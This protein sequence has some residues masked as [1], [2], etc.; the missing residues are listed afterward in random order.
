MF[1]LGFV[2]LRGLLKSKTFT[3]PREESSFSET[4]LMHRVDGSAATSGSWGR[5]THP[6]VVARVT[7][8]YPVA[9]ST[10]GFASLVGNG[11]EPH[12]LCSRSLLT[13]TVR[14]LET[15][16][17]GVTI[18]YELE[19]FCPEEAEAG[20]DVGSNLYGARLSGGKGFGLVDAMLLSEPL[21]AVTI[22]H[23]CRE[24]EVGQ[25]EIATV[26][27]DALSATD[28]LVILRE[29]LQAVAARSGTPIDLAAQPYEGSSG[30]SLQI[31]VVVPGLGAGSEPS[32][33]LRSCVKA[34]ARSVV[35]ATLVFCPL[36][37]SYARLRNSEF[38]AVLDWGVDRRDTVVRLVPCADGQRIEVRLADP[39]A[40]VHLCTHV[41]LHAIV[42][43]LRHKAS[44]FDTRQE[45]AELPRSIEDAAEVLRT[46]RFSGLPVEMR[47]ALLE[48]LTTDSDLEGM[49]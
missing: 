33:E 37:S 14:E 45:R 47:D 12:P 30:S 15:L 27:S 46:S 31:S 41:V 20:G 43:F 13:N 42:A 34:I 11:R 3:T 48:V 26:P 38:L 22:D 49:S 1:E 7:A 16:V 8:T 6:S 32:P 35:E 19:F 10:F 39:R 21:A 17:P 5:R 25:Y 28:G 9:G 29:R 40:N 4:V 18:G 2:D 44:L 36:P 23:A 24:Y